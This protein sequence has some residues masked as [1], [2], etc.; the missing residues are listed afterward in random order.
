MIAKRV[1]FGCVVIMLLLCMLL[2][3]YAAWIS[4]A[5]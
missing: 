2:C 5:F 3:Y 1:L 4:I